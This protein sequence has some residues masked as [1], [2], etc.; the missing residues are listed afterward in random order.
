VVL[1][2]DLWRRV[3]ETGNTEMG[4]VKEAETCGLRPKREP[5]TFCSSHGCTSFVRLWLGAR[6]VSP[7]CASRSYFFLLPLFEPFFLALSFWYRVF[8][9]F[10]I[11]GRTLRTLSISAS[12]H[13]LARILPIMSSFGAFIFSFAI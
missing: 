3:N 5:A 12:L 9:P 11:F 1:G 13:S 8:L 10:A 4:N 2:K 7:P 6:S